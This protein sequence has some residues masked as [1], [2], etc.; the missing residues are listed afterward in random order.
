MNYNFSRTFIN[1][2]NNTTIKVK[3]GINMQCPFCGEHVTG[4]D[5]T[6]P[7]CGADLSSFDDECPFCGVLIDSSEILC[8][9]CG[10]NI[11][12]YWYGER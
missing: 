6:C 12:E 3:G 5:L 1:S 4:G 7:H 9:N 11:C 8:P 2:I 10:V